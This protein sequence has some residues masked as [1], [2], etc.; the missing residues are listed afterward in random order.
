LHQYPPEVVLEIGNVLS[1][2]RRLTHDVVD[3]YEISFRRSIIRED[4]LTYTPKRRY[5]LCISISTFEHIGLDE[6][7][8]DQEKILGLTTS[9]QR[10]LNP[11]GRVI[12]SIPLGYNLF[13]DESIFNGKVPLANCSFMH[14]VSADNRWEQTD[15]FTAFKRQ[16]GKPYP[17]ANALLIGEYRENDDR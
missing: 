7:N 11:G 8:K 17:S 9:F 1:H 6:G 4:V 16:Y 15:M 5:D 14:R 2:Y 12:F 10:F 13:L 3:K